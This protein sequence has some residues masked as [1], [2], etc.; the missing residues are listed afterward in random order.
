MATRTEYDMA[1]GETIQVEYTP[2]PYVPEDTSAL[3]SMVLNNVLV[4]PGSVVRALG[5]VMFQEINKLRV[6]AGLAQY[7]MDQ[8][9]AALKA[10]M[11]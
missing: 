11:R 7:T 8:F 2:D 1:T 4:Q 6:K 5:L 3:D 10:N 9:I